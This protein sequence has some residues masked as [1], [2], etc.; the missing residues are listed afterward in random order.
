MTVID[1]ESSRYVNGLRGVGS[2][3][4]PGPARVCVI[5]ARRSHDRWASHALFNN[6]PK[7]DST[8]KTCFCPPVPMLRA[9]TRGNLVPSMAS[10]SASRARGMES[11]WSPI[12]LERLAPPR[13]S[14]S[15]LWPVRLPTDPDGITRQS[16]ISCP[17]FFSSNLVHLRVPFD[18]PAHL[19]HRIVECEGAEVPRLA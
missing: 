6:S 15:P 13:L 16:K 14:V 7:P 8:V 19:V 5:N 9:Q 1:C 12:S 10:R 17:P 2:G 11:A 3:A 4:R 18:R